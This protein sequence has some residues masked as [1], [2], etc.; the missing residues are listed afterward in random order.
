MPYDR[1]KRDPWWAKTAKPDAGDK[2]S[3]NRGFSS[4]HQVRPELGF[5][6]KGGKEALVGPF[7]LPAKGQFG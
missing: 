7:G 2:G 4:L 1:Q 5:S 3:F 6:T